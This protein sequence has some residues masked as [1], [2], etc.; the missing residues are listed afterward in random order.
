MLMLGATKKRGPPKGYIDTLSDKLGRLEI[1]ITRL[2]KLPNASGILDSIRTQDAITAGIVDSILDKQ[3]HDAVPTS[4]V[5]PTQRRRL[6][7]LQSLQLDVKPQIEELEDSSDEVTDSLGQLSIDENSNIRYHG[8]ASGLHLITNNKRHEQGIWNFPAPGIWPASHELK[9]LTQKEVVRLSGAKQ[10]LPDIQVQ[11]KLIELYFSYVHPVIPIIHKGWFMTNFKAPENDERA[12]ELL[13]TLLLLCVF[14]VA[15]RYSAVNNPESPALWAAGTLYIERAREIAHLD[16]P[17][18]RLSSVQAFLLLT[19]R[20][21][22]LGDMK[23][24]WMFLGHSVRMAEDLGLHR[25]VSHFHPNGRL[26]LSDVQVE[27]RK[28]TWHG[29]VI[30]DTYISSYIGR[31]TAIRAKDYDTRGCKEDEIEESEAWQPVEAHVTCSRDVCDLSDQDYPFNWAIPQTGHALSC[32]N[33][34]SK[35]SALENKILESCYSIKEK[36]NSEA[37]QMSLHELHKSVDKWSIDLPRHLK[38]QA[39]SQR[40]PPP[41]VLTLHTAFHCT[42]ILL[43]RP[44]VDIPSHYPSHQIMTMAA[45]SIT[46]IVNSLNHRHDF[47]NKAPS[48]LIYHVFTAGI[49]HCFN[50]KYPD[51]EPVARQNLTKT[52]EALKAM[53]I[54]WPAAGRAYDML[55]DVYDIQQNQ[56]LDEITDNGPRGI[57]RMMMESTEQQANMGINFS[58]VFPC[59]TEPLLP[60]VPTRH[61]GVSTLNNELSDITSEG[62]FTGSYYMGMQQPTMLPGHNLASSAFYNITPKLWNKLLHFSS[63]PQTGISLQQM[64]MFGSNPSQGT[65]LRAGNFLSEELPIR[66]AHR[67]VELNTLPN[68]LSQMPSIQRVLG[69]YAH[70]FDELINFPPPQLSAEVRNQLFAQSNKIGKLPEAKPNLAQLEDEHTPGPVNPIQNNGSKNRRI[71]IEYRY[72]AE[73]PN[74]EWP[75]EVGEYNEN[76]TRLLE[77]IKKRHDTV[78]PTIA[79][80]V[81]EYKKHRQHIGRG[82]DTD[83]QSF[84]DRFYMS[85]IGIRFLIG[86]HIALNSI[87]QPKDYVGIIC[88]STNVRDVCDEA[89]DN[90]R[91]IAEDHYA[92]FKP[93][94]V[95]LICPE[96]LTISYVP[97]HLNH[98]VFEIIKNS[99]RAVIERFGVDAEDQMPPIKVIVAAGNEDITIKISDEGGGIPRSAI[100]LIWTYMY[101]TMEG[102]GLD[103]E[104]EQSGSDYKAPMA[105]LGYGLPLSRLY[106]RYFGGDLR[107]IS[108]EGYGTD[109]YI[110]LNRLSSSAEPLQ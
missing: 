51:I 77:G 10:C 48:L 16:H 2:A 30:L 65:L 83:I 11:D 18:S 43:H 53:V 88:K 13:P 102:K 45:N 58:N 17:N 34:L 97:G 23:S 27:A 47:L 46:S 76:F 91:F 52:M 69:W 50:L 98:I 107:L 73:T 94:Q 6:N 44:F 40:L 66:L 12:D 80:G 41:N 100:P 29:C 87:N 60:Q 103:P 110:H 75:I 49:T 101:T 31:P 57:K 63:F 109:V 105:G 93:P 104:F 70:S 72:H 4:A 9:K 19:Y 35:L 36:T 24:A 61:P 54:T 33:Q 21:V 74:Y 15:S 90:A 39:S 82:V 32:F 71:P 84:L 37:A 67:C 5:N 7:S 59:P 38:F 56:S 26:R 95:Q 1:V 108:M 78:V 22:G 106:A 85:R 99:L 42:L 92:L 64:V 25:D 86:Q 8:K 79:Q 96:D 20:S 3:L 68:N 81:L 55:T 28:R 62:P 89:I 14:G